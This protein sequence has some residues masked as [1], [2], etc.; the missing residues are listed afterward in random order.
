MTT[1]CKSHLESQV[2]SR[3]KVSLWGQGWKS[4]AALTQEIMAFVHFP[5]SWSYT[6]GIQWQ[7]QLKM[8]EGLYGAFFYLLLMLL[9][10]SE[11]QEHDHSAL[12][13]D[14]VTK[15]FILQAALTTWEYTEKLGSM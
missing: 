13:I 14:K 12:F 1:I 10:C 5:G 8:E 11:P 6:S 2:T 9:L 3:F 15:H 4:T 7:V